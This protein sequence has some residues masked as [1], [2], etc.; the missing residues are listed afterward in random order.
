MQALYGWAFAM[1]DAL[2][3]L[4]A[5]SDEAFNPNRCARHSM[6]RILEIL[7]D[8]FDSDSSEEEA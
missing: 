5:I 4:F 2:E 6:L 7:D 1:E 3:T 8:A